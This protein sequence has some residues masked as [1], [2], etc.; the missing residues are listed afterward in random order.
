[1]SLLKLTLTALQ[2]IRLNWLRALLTL[3]GI[4]IGVGSV[5]VM[6]AL[7]RG[8]QQEVA[9]S[10]AA[11]GDNLVIV[12]SG[13]RNFGGVS[14]GAG[15]SNPLD[16][17]DVTFLRENLRNMQY[18]SPVVRAPGQVVGGVG[19]W[20]TQSQGVGEQFAEIRSW[21]LASGVFFT[22]REI[23]SRAPVAVLGQTVAQQ[24]FP[25]R[26]P[27]GE[28]IRI[29]RVPCTIVGVLEA[30]GSSPF[31]GDQD[32]VVYVPWT[33]AQA[34]MTGNKDIMQ[35]LISAEDEN[36]MT[37][38]QEEIATLLRRL[39]RLPPEAPDD[40]QLR[41]QT[42]IMNM[43]TE[44]T[45]TFTTLLASVA[46]ISLLVGG[47]GIM[48]MMLVAVT[49]RTREIG[50]RIALGARPRDIRAQF[51]AES[52]V[53]CTIGGLLGTGIGLSVSAGIAKL[54][55]F[56]TSVDTDMMLIAVGFAA[57]VGVFF[58]LYPAI[59]ASKLDPIEALRY[60]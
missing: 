32:D 44:M 15:S 45:R 43:R 24:L 39:H 52:V 20:F 19:N 12:S 30:K 29:G 48:N 1:M 9:K 4:V 54:M 42:E 59:R 13:N 27:V 25:D 36:G 6:T 28:K 55:G 3:L 8:A 51:L 49:E 31:G 18:L 16:S 38:L 57:F 22:T 58:G 26:D 14:M 23:A 56:P 10:V 34:R 5:I 33:T 2:S 35:I 17:E 46:A 7:G 50:L 53:I 21:P 11:M 60:S 37:A 40:F 47:I 41:N